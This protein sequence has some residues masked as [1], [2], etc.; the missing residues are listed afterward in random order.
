[1]LR[2][3]RFVPARGRGDRTFIDAGNFAPR[4]IFRIMKA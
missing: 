1:V 4:T 3:T 2:R